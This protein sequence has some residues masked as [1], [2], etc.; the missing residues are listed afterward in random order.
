MHKQ[1]ARSTHAGGCHELEV[2]WG[3]LVRRLV[4]SAEKVRFTGSGT[5]ATLMAL[6]LARIFTGRPIFCE[7]A[8]ASGSSFG[9]DLPPND[10]P[11]YGTMTRTCLLG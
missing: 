9:N 4:P 11:T 2:E 8:A 10:P 1:V 6:R 5:E 7:S 3:E